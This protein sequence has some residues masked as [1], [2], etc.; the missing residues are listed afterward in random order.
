MTTD[1][2]RVLLGEIG[3][4]HGIRG[5]VLVRSYTGAPGDIAAYGPLKDETGCKTL[6]LD[7]VRLTDKGVVVRVAGVGDR[8]AAEKLR[9]TKLYVARDKL[10]ATEAGEYYH[11]DLIG[12]E[13]VTA[14][15]DP[16]G[17]VVAVQN[18]GAGDLIEIRLAGSKATELIPFEAA[19]VPHVDIG[20]GRLTVV[21]PIAV[22][23]GEGET[24]DDGND[25]G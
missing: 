16:F 18:F 2:R 24:P 15:G 10:P 11:N 5:E 7:V 20:Q 17:H 8:T 4:A 21:L 9:G 1:K 6:T 14:E 13:A 22:E 23:G 25:G 19:F 12:L 3:P